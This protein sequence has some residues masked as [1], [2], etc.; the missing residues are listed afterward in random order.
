MS[1]EEGSQ[2]NVSFLA[3]GENILLVDNRGRRYLVELKSGGEFHCHSGVIRHD[4]I[5]G[6]SEGS[7]FRTASNAKFIGLR[8]T[9]N[10]HVLKMPRGAQVIYPKDLGAIL[11]LA[12]IAAG[13]KVFES[14]LGSGALSTALLRCGVDIVGYEI[15]EDFA[16]TA[17][18]NVAQFLGQE[19]LERY[20]VSIK[21][22]YEEHS[23]GNFDRAVLDL[24]EPWQVVPHL[25][26]SLRSGGILVA[27][28][29]SIIQ[30][31][32][33]RRQLSNGPWAMVETIEV[34]HR[35]WHVEGHAVRPDHRMV[36]HTG[37]LTH[38]RLIES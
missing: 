28:N 26:Q 34:L 38:A 16:E 27:Y 20:H 32:T 35:S 33:L 23:D 36:A 19:A 13:Q 17:I 4:Q 10:D 5:I 1:Q 14:G 7:E 18:S 21:D 25:E 12:D 15:R 24:P 8:P 31:Q 37:F 9:I 11:I 3:E 6:S 2:G 22:A 30:V 29:P